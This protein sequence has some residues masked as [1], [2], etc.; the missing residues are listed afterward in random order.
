MG[1]L[2]E[3]LFVSNDLESED[4]KKLRDAML[5]RS[6]YPRKVTYHRKWEHTQL[7]FSE[8]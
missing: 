5:T 1:K 2:S 4:K 3:L 8:G 7:A 6:E